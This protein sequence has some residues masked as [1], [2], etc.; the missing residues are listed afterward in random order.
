MPRIAVPAIFTW[1][2][3]DFRNQSGVLCLFSLLQFISSCM[4]YAKILLEQ[5]KVFCNNRR[6]YKVR[7]S[8][9]SRNPKATNTAP[10][11]KQNLFKNYGF[12]LPQE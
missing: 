11:P 12:L 9:E 4:K 1:V 8:C 5:H 10:Q 7:H 3:A 2:R 6:F